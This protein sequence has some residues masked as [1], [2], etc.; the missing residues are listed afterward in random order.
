MDKESLFIPEEQQI[1]KVE[2]TGEVQENG[3]KDN[4]EFNNLMEI[5]DL[6][7]TEY[8]DEYI[9]SI[10][11]QFL[12][13]KSVSMDEETINKLIECGKN[14]SSLCRNA[15]SQMIELRNQKKLF[16]QFDHI[17]GNAFLASF[18]SLNIAI[19]KQ[20]FGEYNEIRFLSLLFGFKTASFVLR[21]I[22]QK[23]KQIISGEAHTEDFNT[24]TPFSESIRALEDIR[25]NLNE[26][27]LMNGKRSRN[28]SIVIEA[29]SAGIQITNELKE[30]FE[31]GENQVKL[32]ELINNKYQE[33]K[34]LQ[35]PWEKSL[36]RLVDEGLITWKQIL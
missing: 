36:N 1:Q 16:I 18:A 17:M 35:L 15:K 2:Q 30:E 31:N 19:E 10:V 6:I 28:L 20:R 8:S 21:Q 26:K 29:E 22:A 34:S 14:Y 32:D 3:T 9:E 7:D 11:A 24:S 25:A 13:Q 4:P 5:A 33:I 27:N 23:E 12:H